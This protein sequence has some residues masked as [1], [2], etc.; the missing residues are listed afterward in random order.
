MPA[1]VATIMALRAE[2]LDPEWGLG[3]LAEGRFRF[4]G[5][6]GPHGLIA[7]GSLRDPVGIVVES[8]L[9]KLLG[10]TNIPDQ[11]Y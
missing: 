8:V 5:S 11:H 10:P 7:R 2:R 9:T 6:R 1:I 4:I 3:I